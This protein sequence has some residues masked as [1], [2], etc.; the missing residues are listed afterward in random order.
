M[1]TYR[2]SH[3]SDLLKVPIE[4]REVCLRE[5][6]YGLATVD[7]VLGDDDKEHPFPYI[8]WTDDG[9]VS[10]DVRDQEGKPFIKLQVTEGST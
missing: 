10:V 8:D 1:T 6:A 4:R 5:L 2:I 3:I 9:D 7:L